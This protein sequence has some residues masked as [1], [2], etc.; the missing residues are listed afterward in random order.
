MLESIEK[1]TSMQFYGVGNSLGTV[2]NSWQTTWVG[3]PSTVSTE[4]QSTSGS[5]NG[6]PL[7][8]GTWQGMEQKLQERLQKH[9]KY[10]QELVSQLL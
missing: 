1:E 10:K 7:Q 6:D 8:G 3:E 9:L 5:W 2:W 4:V